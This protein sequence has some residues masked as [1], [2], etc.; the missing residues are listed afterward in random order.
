MRPELEWRDLAVLRAWE[1]WAEIA[2]PAPWLLLSLG[3]AGCG[4][5]IAA[6]PFSFYFF[7]CGLRQCHDC[8]HG[9]WG[10]AR[11]VADGMLAVLS[12]LMLGSMH[13]VRFNHLRHHTDCLG[14]DD[15]E[16]LSARMSGLRAILFGPRFPLL[17]HRA[18]WRGAPWRQ[19]RWIAAELSL[20]ALWLTLV[21]ALLD[22]AAL[23]YHTLAMGAG[24]CLTA[25]FAV[26]TVHRDCRGSL[27]SAR[28][29][30][31]RWKSLVAQDMFF[32]VEHHLY[33]RVP[34]R[35]LPELARRLDAACPGLKLPSVY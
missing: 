29:L 18:A 8:F 22:C 33:P 4:W 10:V 28:S 21:F 32:H 16:A 6:L 19:R 9:N 1:V 14:A 31:N 34:T 26:W 3:L 2:R 25:F 27:A 17:L 15:V 7:L 35:R 23:R 12:V 24:Q 11:G 20:N 5:W 13:A 30:R